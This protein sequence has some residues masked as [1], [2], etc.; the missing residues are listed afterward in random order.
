MKDGLRRKRLHLDTL[1][2]SQEALHWVN[3]LETRADKAFYE[4]ASTFQKEERELE[5][6]IVLEE[7]AK[8]CEKADISILKDLSKALKEFKLDFADYDTSQVQKFDASIMEKD[9]TGYYLLERHFDSTATQLPVEIEADGNCF[10]SSVSTA[11]VGNLDLTHEMRLNS[12]IGIIDNLE[13]AVETCEAGGF[14]FNSFSSPNENEK[15]SNIFAEL[16][17]HFSRNDI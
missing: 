1:N 14:T 5:L 10:Y 4:T 6:T 12:L 13:E 7:S 8:L 2:S 9:Q 3:N 15:L 16:K 11:I 17:C